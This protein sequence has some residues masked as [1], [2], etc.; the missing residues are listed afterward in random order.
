MNVRALVVGLGSIGQR[1]ARNLRSIL[2]DDLTL[3]AL[4]SRRGGCIVTDQLVSADG[5]P[6]ADCDGGIFTDLDQALA[7]GPDIV[8][9]SNPTS[10]HAEIVDAAVRAGAAVFVEK[11]LSHALRGINELAQ[12]VADRN[13]IVSIGFQFRYHPALLSMQALLDDRV[14]GR[15]ISVH[16]VQAEYLPL[17]HPYEDYRRSYAARADLGGGVVLTQIHEIDYVHWL[18]GMPSSVFAVGGRVSELEIDVEDTASALL[19]YKLDGKALAVHLHLD[20]LQRPSTRSCTVIGENGVIA[21]DLRQPSL[22]WSDAKGKVV[23][24][25]RYPGFERNQMFLDEM[26]HFLAAARRE[27]PVE[28]DLAHGIDTLRIALAIRRSLSSGELERLG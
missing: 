24:E 9:V 13:A 23:R 4:R 20:Y 21:V 10:L 12:L 14:L 18:F 22:T 28:V 27:E 17:F 15:L 11:P 3:F 26:R 6:E 7:S 25:E 16:A 2:G 1:H 19:A 5:D 8:V